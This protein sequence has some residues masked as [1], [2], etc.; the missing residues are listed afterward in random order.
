[1]ESEVCCISMAP[2]GELR[3]PVVF[4]EDPR[5]PYECE[6]LVRWLQ[7]RQIC[8]R[9]NRPVEWERTASEIIAA[10]RAQDA[11]VVE[12]SL[13][14]LDRPPPW[15]FVIGNMRCFLWC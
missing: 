10:A 2:Y 9:T 4:R 13:K 7:V 6:A 14:S 15:A 12:A 11:A 3:L 5:H 1:M 8:P